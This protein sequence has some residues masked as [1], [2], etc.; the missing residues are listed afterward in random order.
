M[1]TV[2]QSLLTDKSFLLCASSQCGFLPGLIKFTF[3]D[4]VSEHIIIH[5]SFLCCFH[6]KQFEGQTSV[7]VSLLDLVEGNIWIETENMS[8]CMNTSDYN[9]SPEHHGSKLAGTGPE[10]D[11]GYHR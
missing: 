4:T 10:I 3:F 7:N 5:H 9:T 11:P 2:N 8:S 1:L 6:V